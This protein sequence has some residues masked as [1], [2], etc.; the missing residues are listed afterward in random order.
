MP[1][2]RHASPTRDKISHFLAQHSPLII[3]AALCIVFA[4]VSPAFRSPTSLQQIPVRTATITVMA[5][6][7][8]LVILTAGIDLSVGSVA[9]LA[10]ITG[11]LVMTK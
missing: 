6:G 3:F 2:K 4:M 10:G 7:E 11:C 1:G 9:A 5:I 8:L